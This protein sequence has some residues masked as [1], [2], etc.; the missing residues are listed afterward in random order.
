[1]CGWREGSQLKRG[2]HRETKKPR[3]AL[4]VRCQITNGRWTIGQPNGTPGVGVPLGIFM[5][6]SSTVHFARVHVCILCSSSRHCVCTVW[7]RANNNNNIIISIIDSPSSSYHHHHH[8][9]F[10]FFCVCFSMYINTY[11]YVYVCI[12]ESIWTNPSCIIRN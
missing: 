7:E 8:C 1:M 2:Q 4:A 12:S 11:I 10:H 5:V 6:E 9:Y 3:L